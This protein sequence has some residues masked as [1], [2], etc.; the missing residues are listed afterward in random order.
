[1]TSRLRNTADS[2]SAIFLKRISDVRVTRTGTTLST[3][4]FLKLSCRGGGGSGA[5]RNSVALSSHFSEMESRGAFRCYLAGLTR[6]R[7]PR[8][9]RYRFEIIAKKK[10]RTKDFPPTSISLSLSFC[11]R[12]IEILTRSFGERKLR[13][14]TARISLL[15][16]SIDPR[17]LLNEIRFTLQNT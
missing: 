4:C 7:L 10:T 16:R 3:I 5:A 8:G 1:M 17:K 9:I 13:E 14:R 15:A 2:H 6:F 12:F 11:L